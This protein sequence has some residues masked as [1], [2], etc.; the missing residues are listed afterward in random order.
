[1]LETDKAYMAAILDGE[2]CVGMRQ[3]SSSTCFTPSLRVSVTNTNVVLMTW[4]TSRFGG[5]VVHSTRK[6]GNRKP[7][8][9]WWIKG[10]KAQAFLLLLK[11]YIILKAEHVRLALSLNYSVSNRITD[12]ERA[13]R[14]EAFERFK[15]LN[16]RGINKE[17]E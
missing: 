6:K 7:S 10:K 2:G 3:K 12:E 11:P 4:I 5:W 1:M 13:L 9:Q 16:H 8:H 14:K 15:V 17:G